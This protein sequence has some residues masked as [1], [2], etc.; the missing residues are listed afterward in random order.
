MQV[1]SGDGDE[2]D[3]PRARSEGRTN[4]NCWISRHDALLE[5]LE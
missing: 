3:A 4:S 5:A 1:V 2:L